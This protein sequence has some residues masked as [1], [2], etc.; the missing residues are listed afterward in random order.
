MFRDSS[1]EIKN[2]S[3]YIMPQIRTMSQLLQTLKLKNLS[4]ELSDEEFDEFLSSLRRTKGKEVILQSL[5]QQKSPSLMADMLEI[6]SN[7]IRKRQNQQQANNPWTLDTLPKSFIGEIASNLRQKDYGRFSRVNRAIYMG[8]NDPNRLLSVNTEDVV[9]PSIISYQYPQL[10]RLEISARDVPFSDTNNQFFGQLQVLVLHRLR[11]ESD[12]L[13]LSMP[14]RLQTPRLQHLW[15]SSCEFLSVD[16][17]RQFF[18]KFNM[19]RHL[20]LTMGRQRVSM[21]SVLVTKSF[22][23]LQSLTACHYGPLTNQFLRY[24]GPDLY[25]LNL[26]SWAQPR[27]LLASENIKKIKLQKLQRLRISRRIPLEIRQRIIQTSPN[28]DSVCYSIRARSQS[29]HQISQFITDILTKKKTLKDLCV[30]TFFSDKLDC[31]SKAIEIGLQS[32]RKWKRKLLKIGIECFVEVDVN[33]GVVIISRILNR[34]MLC[35][36]DEYALFL[37]LQTDSMYRETLINDVKD[38]V[39]GLGNVELI[40]SEGCVFI[41]RSKGSKINMYKKWWDEGKGDGFPVI[42]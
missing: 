1:L 41:I 18:G 16:I 39:D 33:E 21:P 26:E 42:Y 17:T 8:C 11:G 25:Q 22:P 27:E 4:S 14:D 5:C 30:E 7:I 6:A 19:I 9:N 3:K 37:N 35:N 10:Q 34:L 12:W 20:N 40:S 29:N 2:F 28:L 24:R 38:L 15:L 23:N 13:Y 32:T 31:I 36:I